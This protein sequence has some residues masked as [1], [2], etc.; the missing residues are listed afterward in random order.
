ML[1]LKFIQENQELVIARL[2]KKYFDATTIVQQI[3]ELSGKKNEIQASADQCK[4]E[5]NKISK[6]IGL[7]M[8]DGKKDEAEAAKN[9]TTELKDTIKQLDEDF[10]QADKDVF[11]LQVL[12]PNLPAEI[13]PEGRT[14][15]DNLTVKSQGEIPVLPENSVPH[16]DLAKKYDIIDFELGVKITG[17]GF[18]VYKGKGARLQRALINFFL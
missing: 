16:W 7:L 10:A 3:A 17:A 5:M 14:P 6:E 1:N 18:P 11:N 9:R 8:R 4:A 12:L 13:V 2:K 15:E